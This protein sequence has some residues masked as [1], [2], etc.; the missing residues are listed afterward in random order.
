MSVRAFDYNFKLLSVENHLELVVLYYRILLGSWN[1]ESRYYNPFQDHVLSI[2]WY[3][4]LQDFMINAI[5]KLR[6]HWPTKVN[7]NSVVAT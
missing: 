6:P 3:M 7:A 1:T 4:P 2:L 5:S